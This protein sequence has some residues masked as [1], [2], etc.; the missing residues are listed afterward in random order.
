MKWLDPKT[1][2]LPEENFLAYIKK[3]N[4]DEHPEYT[5]L[6]IAR[7]SYDKNEYI[8]VAPHNIENN[9]DEKDI[10]CWMPLP[11]SPKAL[12]PYWESYWDFYNDRNTLIEQLPEYN[13]KMQDEFEIEIADIIKS[14]IPKLAENPMSQEELEI[15]RMIAFIESTGRVVN[16]IANRDKKAGDLVIEAYEAFKPLILH[17]LRKLKEIT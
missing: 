9:V 2:P 7:S 1:H 10:L 16:E 11:K 3:Y 17:L 15:R 8:A 6:C 5:I 12:R 4:F 14:S 13:R